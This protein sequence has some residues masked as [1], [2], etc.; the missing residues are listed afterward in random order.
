MEFQRIDGFKIM[1]NKDGYLLAVESDKL[2]ECMEYALEKNI[3]KIS[4][5]SYDGYTLENVSFLRRYNFFKELSI[6]DDKIN[7]ADVH[8]LKKLEYLSLSNGQ[9][10]IDFS[11][12]PNLKEC[13]IDWN[14]RILILSEA[15]NLRKLKI[16]KYKPKSKSFIELNG[17]SALESLAITESNIESFVD[18]G[19]MKNI[20]SFEGHYLSKLERLKGIEALAQNLKILILDFCKKLNKYEESLEELKMLQKLILGNCGEIESIKLGAYQIVV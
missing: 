3:T 8:S 12:F 20:H 1:P 18:I 9:Q 16:W 19:N 4:I 2:E 5:H 11:A 6:T 13:S 14:T 7:I 15:K 17:L 10:S